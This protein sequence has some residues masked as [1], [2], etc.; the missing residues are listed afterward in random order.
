MVVSAAPSSDSVSANS[1]SGN[2]VGG[3]SASGINSTQAPINAAFAA[4]IQASGVSAEV[5]TAAQEAGLS[6][7]EYVNNS[8]IEVPGLQNVTPVGQ[9]DKIIVDGKKTNQTFSLRKPAGTYVTSAKSQAA[10]LGGDVLNVVNVQ[11]GIAS[12]KTATVNFYMPGVKTGENIQVYRYANGQWN[13]LTISEVRDDH[14]VVDMTATGVLAF[15]Q[16]K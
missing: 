10:S 5:Y 15:I 13:S 16:V 8:I 6:V 12:G 7:T 4:E 1:I 11:G 9:G 14:V 3:G 2:S